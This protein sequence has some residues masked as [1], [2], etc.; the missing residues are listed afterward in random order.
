MLQFPLHLSVRDAGIEKQVADETEAGPF[1]EADRVGLGRKAD[2]RQPLSTA[3][4]PMVPFGCMRAVA[5]TS[6][7][8]SQAAT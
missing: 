4:R 2:A 7:A 3:M 1:V 5:I 6:P 8:S